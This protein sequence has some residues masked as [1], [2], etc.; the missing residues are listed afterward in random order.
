VK[1]NNL[2][3]GS[4]YLS[5]LYLG[6]F[7]G[8]PNGQLTTDDTA[9]NLYWKGTQLNGGGGGGGDVTTVNLTSTVSG[10]GSSGYLSTLTST[11]GSVNA[12]TATLS[13]L[14]LENQIYDPFFSP[15]PASL[16]VSDS[17]L[18]YNAT[19]GMPFPPSPPGDQVAMLSNVQN[20]AL[21]PALSSIRFSNETENT[22]NQI[23]SPGNTFF[24]LVNEIGLLVTTSTTEIGVLPTRGIFAK[25]LTLFDQLDPTFAVLNNYGYVLTAGSTL[26]GTISSPVFV[27]EFQ[28]NTVPLYVSSL[29]LGAVGGSPAGELT[30]D[31]TATKLFYSTNQLAN[32]KVNVVFSTLDAGAVD[33]QLY[34]YDV[35]KYF[36]FSTTTAGLVVNLPSV[37]NGWNAVIKNLEGSTE[38]L[39]VNAIS[40][41]ALAPGVVTTV[42]CDGLSFYSL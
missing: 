31:S 41:V 37:E 32:V 4:L 7:G 42:V 40:Q 16:F 11:F 21:Y 38:T 36:L 28:T 17:I 3:T 25:N 14:R 18:Y 13:T 34:S 15:L 19:G 5:S 22:L 33:P 30:T 9:T 12:D 35:G 39:K 26:T 2:Q 10:L 23:I 8:T 20:W 27:D 6:A 1:D 29:F 24:N